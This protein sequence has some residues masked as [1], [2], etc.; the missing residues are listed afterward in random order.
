MISAVKSFFFFLVGGNGVEEQD[1][2]ALEQ[3]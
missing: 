2:I 1:I 3:S